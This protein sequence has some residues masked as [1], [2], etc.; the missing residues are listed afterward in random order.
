[1]L[2]PQLAAAGRLAL[3]STLAL[4]PLQQPRYPV[5]TATAACVLPHLAPSA[6]IVGS[7]A[8]VPRTA[9]PPTP[10]WMTLD[11]QGDVAW[12]E[13]GGPPAA[14]RLFAYNARTGHAAIVPSAYAQSGQRVGLIAVSPHWLVFSVFA[15]P[16]SGGHW[17]IVVR[18]RQSSQ[19]KVV[20]ASSVGGIGSAQFSL[21]GDMLAWV[22]PVVPQGGS[23]EVEDLRS[24]DTRVLARTREGVYTEVAASGGHAVWEW[25]HRVQGTTVSDIL[26]TRTAGGAITHLT[27]NARAAEPALTWPR[28]IYTLSDRSGPSTFVVTF[29]V[30]DLQ[31]Q[32]Q[33]RLPMGHDIDFP[34][35]VGD[36]I[37]Y[38]YTGLPAFYSLASGKHVVLMQPS[39]YLLAG[40]PMFTLHLDRGIVA[41]I[42]NDGQGHY[43]VATFHL[44]G[45]DPLNDVLTCKAST[46]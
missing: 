9:G 6:I 45:A 46:P 14:G 40:A 39:Q 7:L 30:R 42:G 36:L 1:M 23:L 43:V 24:G 15:D 5:A 29:V 19:E 28:V 12:N 4:I 34:R 25:V 27:H 41:A 22:Q 2:I 44:H 31:T 20:A 32:R 35:V 13:Q 10:T 26:L 33:W 17:R 37:M 38:R 16:F 21:D 8:S 11:R 3:V 18:D